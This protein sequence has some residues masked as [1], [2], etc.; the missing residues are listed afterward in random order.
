VAGYVA[1]V[2]TQPAVLGF[3]LEQSRDELPN[4]GYA[5]IFPIATIAK[6]IIAQVLLGLL[7]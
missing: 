5:A 2:H 1:G 4:L 7:L 3:A 6:I